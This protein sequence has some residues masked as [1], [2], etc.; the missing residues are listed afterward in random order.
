MEIKSAL[1][2]AMD[3]VWNA[4]PREKV[5]QN[6]FK[7]TFL[8]FSLFMILVVGWG[9][10]K[11]QGP[12]DPQMAPIAT[13]FAE[14]IATA[15]PG[16]P[17]TFAEEQ[18]EPVDVP[19]IQLPATWPVGH[20]GREA[21]ELFMITISRYDPNLGGPNCF[22]WSYSQNRCLSRTASGEDWENKYGE[23]AACAREWPFGTI[24]ELD[25]TFWRCSD[26][27][28]KIVKNAD[29]SYWVDLLLDHSPYGHGS[30][31]QVSVWFPKE[32]RQ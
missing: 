8:Y 23:I 19:N 31:R 1:E 11:A 14:E 24:F 16:H 15:D 27:G 21:D 26:R 30:Y 25:G 32:T 18:P 9:S 4:V 2:D 20:P 10:I 17:L 7:I 12:S 22:T 3:D 5:R 28:G 13:A 6:A 29:G